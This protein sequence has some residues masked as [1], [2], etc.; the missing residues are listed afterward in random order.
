MTLLHADNFSI[1]GTDIGNMTDG[2]YASANCEIVTDPDGVSEGYVM[3]SVPDSVANSTTP[4]RYAFQN[5]AVSTVGLAFR[6]WLSSLPNNNDA[7][8]R[9]QLK[10]G[11]NSAVGYM[12]F[13]STGQMAITLTG[14]TT[15]TTTVPVITAAGW[16][17]IEWKYTNTSGSIDFEVRIEGD[18]KLSQTGVTGTDANPAQMDISRNNI[19]LSY[20]VY[21]KDLVIWDGTG[22][23]NNDF[24]GSVLVTT[25]SPES[26]VALNWAPSTG[27]AGY[28]ILDNVPPNDA[29]YISAGHDP[30]PDPYLCALSVLPDDVTSVKGL[31]TYV[32]AQKSDGG[33]GSLQVSLLSHPDTDPTLTSGADRPITVAQTYWR[34]I[35][36]VDPVTSSP[37]VPGA[38]N[39]VQLQLDRTT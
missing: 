6:L 4:F 33:D 29:Q 1:Y 24:L 15:Y 23:F 12:W 22:S 19:S 18:E 5:G 17:H 25:L 35:F 34:D 14:G 30:V 7:K 27:S 8:V 20:N 2:I 16:Y 9:I 26:D 39:D 3:S 21:M 10:D 28:S 11:T 37:W 13:T 31:V 32:R 38:V 36:E